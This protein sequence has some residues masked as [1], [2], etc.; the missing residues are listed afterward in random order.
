LLP[1]LALPLLARGDSPV[2]WGDPTTLQGWWRLVS[3]RIYHDNAL[4]LPPAAW[5][6][7]L[8]SWGKTLLAGFLG[9]GWV[10][11]IASMATRGK[12]RRNWALG[13]TAVL[14]LLYAFTYR[15]P[16]ALVLTLPALLLLT[17]P[18]A[19]GL[20][21]VGNAALL[22]PLAL[23]LINFPSQRLTIADSVRPA[24]VAALAAAPP[25]AIVLTPG[26]ETIFALWYAHHVLGRRPDLILVDANLF[27]FDWY[28][29]RLGDR[30]PALD[31]LEEDN[32]AR[33]RRENGKSR[34]IYEIDLQKLI[35]DE[36]WSLE[37]GE[38]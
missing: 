32:L 28:R 33:F 35:E 13:G 3:G 24:A 37:M 17:P 19:D 16:D 31:A 7:R 6:A 26:N 23:L 14:Y 38:W 29:E 18:L 2:V 4:A 5:P 11:I 8:W 25:E 22:L 15:A 30:H 34:P 21:R 10:L 9:V 12:R 36:A 1:L 27:A 20:R